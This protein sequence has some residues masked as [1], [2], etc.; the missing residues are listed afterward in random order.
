MNHSFTARGQ[1]FV[2]ATMPPIIEQ[3]GEG[4]LHLPAVLHDLRSFAR[5]LDHCQSNLV[6][7]LPAADPVT[8][9][10]R[11]ITAIDP[12]FPDST[13]FSGKNSIH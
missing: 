13:G 2:I 10:L 5:V 1:C 12:D 8:Q 9:P 7:L 4:A 6:R 11:L 3:P